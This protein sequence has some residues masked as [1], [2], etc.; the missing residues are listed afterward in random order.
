MVKIDVRA[1]WLVLL[2]VAAAAVACDEPGRNISQAE[3]L[4]EIEGGSPPFVLDVRTPEEFA[5]GHVPGAVNVPHTELPQR[6]PDLELPQDRRVVVYC[7][8]GRRAGVAEA[9]LRE[10]GFSQVLHLEG[11]MAAW[12]A[13]ARPTEEGR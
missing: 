3:L 7:E 9:S 11:D 13:N 2:L 1:A 8:S 4:A 5:R 10:A 12:R 6:L